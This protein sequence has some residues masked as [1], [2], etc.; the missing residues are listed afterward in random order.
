MT[1]QESRPESRPLISDEAVDALAEALVTTRLDIPH[2]PGPVGMQGLNESAKER[3]RMVAREALEAAAGPLGLH[4]LRAAEDVVVMWAWSGTDTGAHA[5]DR[6]KSTF[7]L[8]LRWREAGGD[9]SPERNAHLTDELVEELAA[10]RDATR[11]ATLE[12]FGLVES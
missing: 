9:D 7:E 12:R 1:D 5:S 6:R 3:A 8:W 4:R 2:V 11:K 10:Q